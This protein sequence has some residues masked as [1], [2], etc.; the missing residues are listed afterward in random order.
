LK[1]IKRRAD[2]GD[3]PQTAETD[4][5]RKGRSHILI[6]ILILFIAAFLL[7]TLSFLSHQRSNEQVL[8]QLR[9]N[10]TN[11][12]KLQDALE[13][14]MR[15]QDQIYVQKSQL[16]SLKKELD[17]SQGD[18][19]QLTEKISALESTLAQQQKEVSAHKQTISAM[20]A[21]VQLQQ[22]LIAG[23][24]AACRKLITDME[25]T[26]LDKLLPTTAT[27]PGGVSPYQMF[28]QVKL[29]TVIPAVG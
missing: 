21:L 28:Q 22:L 4:C 1:V 8:G 23:D 3:S 29:L 19:T 24:P 27:A 16:E 14:N 18:R 13:E 10:V 15:L 17:A 5:S 7:M 20:D 6:Y 12:E 26:G 11:L 9:T 25:T 2:T